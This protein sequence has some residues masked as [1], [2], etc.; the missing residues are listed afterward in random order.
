MV[1]FQYG[2]D[3]EKKESSTGSSKLGQRG[4]KESVKKGKRETGTR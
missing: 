2:E 3:E 1:S 4:E